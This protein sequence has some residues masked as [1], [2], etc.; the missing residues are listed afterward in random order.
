MFCNNCGKPIDDD[1]KLC[2]QCENAA[3]NKAINESLLFDKQMED[4]CADETDTYAYDNDVPYADY[5]LND[6][7]KA[8]KSGIVRSVAIAAAVIGVLAVLLVVF[9]KPIV[10]LFDPSL[11][12]DTPQEPTNT[13]MI[14][15][16]K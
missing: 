14:P 13:S 3:A 8:K 6:A 4:N 1:R 16:R 5:A 10:G 9:W 7:A 11:R 12:F 2:E 15:Q